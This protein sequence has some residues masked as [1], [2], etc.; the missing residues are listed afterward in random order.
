MRVR[1]GVGF[2]AGALAACGLFP[3]LAGLSGDAGDAGDATTLDVTEETGG[4]EAGGPPSCAGS[5]Q[6]AGTSCC[7]SPV[8]P[9]GDFNRGNLSAYPAHVSDFRLDRFEVTVGRFRAYVASNP[10]PPPAGAG[11]NPHEPLSG[12]DSSNDAFFPKSADAI[13]AMLASC[14]PSTWTA[15]PGA[16][17]SLPINCVDWYVAFAFCVWDGGRLPSEAEWN[18]AAAGG[19]DQRVY[20]W[21]VP[22]GDASIDPTLATWGCVPEGGATPC[23]APVGSH[24]LG[25]ARWGQLDMA[26]SLVE[27][28]LDW[29][30]PDDYPLPCNDC[31]DV[32][33]ADSGAR[34]DRPEGDY[35]SANP[36]RLETIIRNSDPPTL[37]GDEIGFRCARDL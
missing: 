6:C 9:G 5:L 11:A 14:S 15:V 36:A 13:T 31:V 21:S 34:A 7:D 30:V 28:T 25:A 27:W 4:P 32:V 23:I 26:G 22:A 20:P 33:Q 37:Y 8:I 18:Y 17:E 24:P 29:G 12:W 19:N 16:N 10:V 35:R 2:A 3:D 1:F